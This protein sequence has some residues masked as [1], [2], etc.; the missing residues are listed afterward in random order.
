MSTITDFLADV[1]LYGGDEVTD[2]GS[3]TNQFIVWVEQALVNRHEEVC[4]LSNKW[5]T[6]T[7]TFSAKGYELAVPT[8]WDR[9]STILLYTDSDHQSDYDLFEIRFGVIRFDMEQSSGISYYRR[10]RLQPS[11]YTAMGDTLTEAANP[12]LKKILMEE[13]IALYSAAQN[14]L[15]TSN[16]EQAALNKANRN[17]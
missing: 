12:R 2:I 1:I 10:Y 15:E 16:A 4:A 9:T 11:T 8:D 14:D 3:D 6:D 17:S 5:T 13:V 7:A